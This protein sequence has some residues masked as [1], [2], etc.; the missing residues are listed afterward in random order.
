MISETQIHPTSSASIPPSAF[1]LFRSFILSFCASSKN[2]IHQS[3]PLYFS[4]PSFNLFLIYLLIVYNFFLLARC[5]T[6]LG[7]FIAVSTYPP[8][9]QP[10]PSIIP[11]IE[12]TVYL[13]NKVRRGSPKLS[14]SSWTS[15]LPASEL[16]FSEPLWVA[17]RMVF[18]ERFPLPPP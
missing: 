3:S 15:L 14:M 16:L 11:V 6:P 18:P 1:V 5:D 2:N 9:P 13:S 10:F 8:S 17:P 4:L 7:P 12:L